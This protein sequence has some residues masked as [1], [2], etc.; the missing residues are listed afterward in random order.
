MPGSGGNVRAHNF[1][2][3]ASK[4]GEV[5]LLS[6]CGATGERFDESLRSQCKQVFCGA[7]SGELQSRPSSLRSTGIGLLT[8]PWRDKWIPFTRGCLQHCQS[9]RK[10]LHWRQRLLGML[11][12]WEHRLLFEF[13]ILPPLACL[14]WR[15]EY[16]RLR[17]AVLTSEPDGGFDLLWVED[18][19]GWPFAEDLGRRLG[20][21]P[22]ITIVNAYNIESKVAFR[23]ARTA[24]DDGQS[25]MFLR[26]MVELERVER[27]A[28]VSA[29]LTF[30]CSD[31]DLTNA[32]ALRV[33]AQFVVVG[34]GVDISYFSRGESTHG[35]VCDST[36]LFTGTFAYGPNTQAA[37]FFAAE[38]MPLIREKLPA[39]RFLIAGARA[40]SAKHEFAADGIDIDCISDPD[41]IRP[42]FRMASVF[43][44][45]ILAGGGTRLKILEAMAMGVPVVSTRLGA[46]G[47]GAEDSRQLLLA[48]TPEELATAVLRLINDNALAKCLVSSAAAWVAENYDWERLCQQA[49]TE[50]GKV[51]DHKLQ[52]S[53]PAGNLR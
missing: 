45:P 52:T 21:K 3:M 50:V 43:V 30:L 49:R 38:V 20:K 13:G 1:V 8:A 36:I 29:D 28:F 9:S 2:R 40:A 17:E 14:T 15:T 33:D 12:R 32:A 25:R 47:L 39:A 4:V 42:A 10:G 27:Q 23:L 46:E 6:L 35:I 7:T 26:N 34:N 16:L 31:M 41:D 19:Y 53:V 5:T 51:L 24:G 48:D 44:V 18:L 22:Q 11:L 37:R